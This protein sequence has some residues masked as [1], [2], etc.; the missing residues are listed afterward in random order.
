MDRNSDFALAYLEEKSQQD[1]EAEQ[2]SVD[3]DD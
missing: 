2:D 3:I 1:P